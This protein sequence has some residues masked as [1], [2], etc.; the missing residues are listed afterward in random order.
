MK[1]RQIVD[2]HLQSAGG[3][4]VE[5]VSTTGAVIADEMKVVPGHPDAKLH[6]R[7]AEADKSALEALEVEDRLV[8]EEVGQW[9]I[10]RL[11]PGNRA[12]VKVREPPVDPHRMHDFGMP[13]P[14]VDL[15]A[16]RVEGRRLTRVQC[17]TVPGLEACQHGERCLCFRVDR[18]DPPLGIGMQEVSIDRDHLAVTPVEGADA[19]IAPVGKLGEGDVTFVRPIKHGGDG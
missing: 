9:W 3:A 12:Q 7:K 6:V 13:D 19:E 4:T 5:D 10:R 2:G 15:R 14:R 17:Q 11:L 18:L 16:K 1:I 8:C